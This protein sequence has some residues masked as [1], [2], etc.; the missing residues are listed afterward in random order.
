MAQDLTDE[1]LMAA[2][3][4]AGGPS[5]EAFA[6]LAG[7]WE[8]RIYAYLVKATRHPE[9]AFDLRQE[10]FLRVWRYRASFRRD[11]AFSHWLFRIAANA[12]RDWMRRRQLRAESS[13]EALREEGWIE[14]GDPAPGPGE[15]AVSGERKRALDDALAA[16][17]IEDR[18][19][20]LLRFFDDVNYRQ[21]SEILELPET[22]VKSRVYRLLRKLRG[23]LEP[24][25]DPKE[26][27]K[28]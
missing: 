6:A 1:Q 7:R 27:A 19:I 5:R 15:T 17:S 11:A 28:R 12:L 4:G 22:T 20:L 10:V 2:C 21:M 9:E 18:Q 3:C 25:C 16:L 8:G 23:E 26:E 14:P 24:R 13:I